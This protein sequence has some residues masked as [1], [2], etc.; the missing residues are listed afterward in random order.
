M[1]M[2]SF[3]ANPN[4][5]SRTAARNA[6]LVNQFATPGLGSLMAHRWIAGLG[7][8]ALAVAGF[9]LIVVWFVKMMFEYYGQMSGD[10]PVKPAGWMGELGAVLFAISWF[11]SLATSIS[12]LRHAKD[13]ALPT[14]V[15]PKLSELPKS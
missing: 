2:K 12:L 1:R 6:F 7:Q 3:S 13:D 8:L 11:W 5:A 4:P 14:A 15:P 10:V 9:A